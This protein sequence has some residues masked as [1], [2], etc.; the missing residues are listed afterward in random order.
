MTKETDKGIVRRNF[1]VCD[2]QN[3]QLPPVLCQTT[4]RFIYLRQSQFHQRSDRRADKRARQFHFP[5]PAC[6]CR[7]SLIRELKRVVPIWKKEI[8]KG[9]ETWIE[10]ENVK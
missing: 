4:T 8:Y 7:L 1:A 2:W 10:G 9:G 5:T 3:F 6:L